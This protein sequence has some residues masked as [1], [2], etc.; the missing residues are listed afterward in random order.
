MLILREP[1]P[2]AQISSPAKAPLTS[3]KELR[4]CAQ[5]VCV[6]GGGRGTRPPQLFLGKDVHDGSR[7][8]KRLR[9]AIKWFK[10]ASASQGNAEA[11]F[12]PGHDVPPAAERTSA[13]GVKWPAAFGLSRDS[14]MPQ[15]IPWQRAY[16]P[17]CQG[18]SPRDPVQAEMWLRLAAKGEFGVLT[19]ERASLLREAQN[20]PGAD[21]QG[22]RRWRKAWKPKVPSALAA[23]TGRKREPEE[24]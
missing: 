10:G 24:N 5:R 19:I 18:T 21:R 11:Q 15:L 22:A 3:R 1:F 17:R 14:R 6:A 7:C 4:Y 2:P 13:E 9:S 23:K 20:D 12:L 16:L 8:S